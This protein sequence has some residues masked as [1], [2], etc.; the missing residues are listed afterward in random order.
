VVI[1]RIEVD[2]F[3]V[4]KEFSFCIYVILM[5]IYEL[6]GCALMDCEI[7]LKSS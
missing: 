1:N 6:P 2:Q 3:I 5:P 7:E 4:L